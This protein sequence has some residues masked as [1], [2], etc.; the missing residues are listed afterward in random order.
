MKLLFEATDTSGDG[1]LS[2]DEFREI[3]Y[4]PW[5]KTWLSA[6]EIS[7]DDVDVL[8]DLV[9][10]DDGRIDPA[11]LV[12]GVSKLKG[13]ARSMDLLA[14]NRDMK[15]HFQKISDQIRKDFES[16]R[17]EMTAFTAGLPLRNTT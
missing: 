3:L 15:H 2:I 17:A 10:E 1:L 9:A 12:H 6:M 14:G 5:V 11:E 4:N 13:T 16:H 8:F 7:T